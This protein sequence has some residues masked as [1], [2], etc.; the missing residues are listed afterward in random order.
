MNGLPLAAAGRFDGAERQCPGFGA[1]SATAGNL[2]HR[3]AIG[4]FDTPM[5]FAAAES[6]FR[7][8]GFGAT[9]LNLL[10][11]QRVVGQR[12][13][14]IGTGMTCASGPVVASPGPLADTLRRAVPISTASPGAAFT[15]WLLP[16]HA[17]FLEQHMDAGALLLWV[18]LAEN[19]LER[20]ASQ[21]LL[22]HSSHPVHVHDISDGP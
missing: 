5:V 3:Y 4:V 6:G 17:Q 10:A 18:R 21:I 7:Q 16:Q 14:L 12:P 13:G 9:A 19:A 8:A 11:G 20:P 15:R 2:D 22:R 1:M